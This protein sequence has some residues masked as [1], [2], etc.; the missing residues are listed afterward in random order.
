MIQEKEGVPTDKQ[1]L[2]FK[3]QLLQDHGTLHDYRIPDGAAITL[4]RMNVHVPWML[5]D[6]S[7]CSL[8]NGSVSPA[9]ILGH[10]I[11]WPRFGKGHKKPAVCTD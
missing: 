11:Y 1:K 2:T 10:I 9:L 8:Q 4:G 6:N 3:Y 7:H 5:Y